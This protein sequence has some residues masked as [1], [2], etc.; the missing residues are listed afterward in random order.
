MLLSHVMPNF[1]MDQPME[2]AMSEVKTNS[3]RSTYESFATT[4]EACEAIVEC[5]PSHIRFLPL[6]FIDAR[7]AA[8]A[9]SLRAAP[10][11]VP[12]LPA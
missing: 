7:L 6:R 8:M 9:I 1:T 4:R 2:K 12:Q 3:S 5:N 11:E 10:N